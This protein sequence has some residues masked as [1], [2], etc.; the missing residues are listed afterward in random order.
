MHKKGI[1]EIIAYVLIVS[2]AVTLGT[3]VTIWYRSTTEKQ[4]EGILN[5]IEGSSQCEDV[6][7]NVAFHYDTCSIAVF[8]TGSITLDAFKVTYSDDSGG[9]N[10]SDY[11]LKIPPRLSQELT[12]PT[13]GIDEQQVETVNVV[14]IIIVGIQPYYCTS[15]YIFTAKEAFHCAA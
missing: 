14:P 9:I 11:E 6:N 4:V 10:T 3:I 2:M 8:N 1:S 7:V 13:E 5:P 12:L 15:N